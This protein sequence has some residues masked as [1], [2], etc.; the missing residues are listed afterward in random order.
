MTQHPDPTFFDAAGRALRHD[1]WTPDRQRVFLSSIADGDTVFRACLLAGMSVTSV[2]AFRQRAAG[3]AFALGWR[4][5]N[6]LAREAIAD[7]MMARAVDGQT[8]SV[9]R[10]DGSVILRH[11]YDNRT[12]L[13]LLARLDRMVE[14]TPADPAAAASSHA[15]RLVAQDFEAFL[16]TI[17][18]DRGPAQAGVFLARRTGLTG[19]PDAAPE[20]EPI[21]A[22]ARADLF[23]RTGASFAEEVDTTDL[24]PTQRHD[25]TAEQWQRADGAGLVCV[26]P[27]CD[28]DDERVDEDGEAAPLP[29]LVMHERQARCPYWW[30]D[31]AEEYRTHLPPPADEQ[32]AYEPY[33]FGE[34]GYKRTLTRTE[35]E[36]I[37]RLHALEVAARRAV[38]DAEREAAL[39]SL[40]ADIGAF[41]AELQHAVGG[42]K[43]VRPE[44]AAVSMVDAEDAAPQPEVR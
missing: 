39:A 14:Q 2:Y 28:V 35:Q 22:L 23:I 7:R 42:R 10:P 26:A 17:E 18:Q 44:P 8:E 15:A 19:V 24:D 41:E 36:L 5:A 40:R 6:L 38:E 4:A 20:L 25:W 31:E 11:R 27:S 21:L 13:T 1:G 16:D 34:S 33:P 30:D 9:T 43:P 12:A 3:A 29:Q 37:D 32:P